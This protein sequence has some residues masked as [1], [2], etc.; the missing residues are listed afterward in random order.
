MT[1]RARQAEIEIAEIARER[2]KENMVG[3]KTGRWN[4]GQTKINLVTETDTTIG[5]VRL[6]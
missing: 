3:Q 1:G 2:D 6:T 4:S 5:G